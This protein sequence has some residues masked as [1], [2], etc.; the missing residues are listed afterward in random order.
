MPLVPGSVVS[1]APGW[2][3]QGLLQAYCGKAFNTPDGPYRHPGFSA[4]HGSTRSR[5]LAEAPCPG[6]TGKWLL[7][8]AAPWRDAGAGEVIVVELDSRIRFFDA[9]G[10]TAPTARSV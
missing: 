9:S 7:E 2:N 8:K 6:E 1:Y 3:V 4:G 10:A 5:D